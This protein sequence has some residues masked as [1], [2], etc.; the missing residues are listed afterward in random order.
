MKFTARLS[1]TFAGFAIASL[2]LAVAAVPRDQP[3]EAPAKD[4]RHKA[5]RLTAEALQRELAPR[6]S[7]FAG[8]RQSEA[9][10][11]IIRQELTNALLVHFRSGALVGTRAEQ[12][13]FVRCDRTT[14]TQDELA[15]GVLKVQVGFAP[16]K[17]AEF[18]LLTLQQA[19]RPTR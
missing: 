19:V 11:A 2:A 10:W 15:R 9:L 1:L 14:M 17:P 3:R 13:F 5:A 16:L 8:E 12:A 7:R 6:L 4:A 18:E